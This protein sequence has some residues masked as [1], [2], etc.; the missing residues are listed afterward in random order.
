MVRHGLACEGSY[1]ANSLYVWSASGR[2]VLEQALMW[3]I[4]ITTRVT[5]TSVIWL[6]YA[7]AVTLERLGMIIATENH[8]NAKPTN[9]VLS[10]TRASALGNPENG[11]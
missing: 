7:I 10:L 5:T 11:K 9:R 6:V 1:L 3:I 4:G 8:Q 2:D